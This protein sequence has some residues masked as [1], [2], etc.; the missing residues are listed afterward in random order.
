MKGLIKLIGVAVEN[1]AKKN[2]N[3]ASVLYCYQPKMPEKLAKMT[4]GNKKKNKLTKFLR[5][6][7]FLA[8][9]PCDFLK[10]EYMIYTVQKNIYKQMF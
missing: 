5:Q 6:K 7:E 10:G 4:K 1:T 3:S 9:L 2:V 8:L